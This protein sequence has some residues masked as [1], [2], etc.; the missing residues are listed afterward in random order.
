MMDRFSTNVC[1]VWGGGLKRALHGAAAHL[2]VD[3]SSKF[4]M[5]DGWAARTR[6]DTLRL[7]QTAKAPELGTVE[8]CRW[9]AKIAASDLRQK[10]WPVLWK[11]ELSMPWEQNKILVSH[12]PT[13]NDFS[14]ITA[15][16]F[17]SVP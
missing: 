7:P 6:G 9:L 16:R 3:G 5:E 12:R 13:S 10:G 11:H 4:G 14:S 2:L 17:N 8:Q 1:G 15:F